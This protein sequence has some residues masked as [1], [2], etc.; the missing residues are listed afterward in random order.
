MRRSSAIS[1]AS[2]SPCIVFL[3]LRSTHSSFSAISASQC[4]QIQEQGGVHRRPP[5]AAAGSRVVC[6]TFQIDRGAFNF[7][8]PSDAGEWSFCARHSETGSVH[9]TCTRMS[10]P[11]AG[12][13]MKEPLTGLCTHT[14]TS[15]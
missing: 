13:Q 6:I 2:R 8:A 5:K 15:H 14:H 3:K 1:P 10:L 4:H 7:Q 9:A 11:K 12:W